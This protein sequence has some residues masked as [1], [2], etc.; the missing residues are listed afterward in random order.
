MTATAKTSARR[1][2]WQQAP[3]TAEQVKNESANVKIMMNV[4]GRSA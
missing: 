4:N 1:R 3:C 2:D